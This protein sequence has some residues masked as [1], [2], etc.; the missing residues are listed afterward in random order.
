M[1]SLPTAARPA[2]EPIP[3]LEDLLMTYQATVPLPECRPCLEEPGLA[4]GAYLLACLCT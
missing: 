3:T 2:E 4:S 1:D